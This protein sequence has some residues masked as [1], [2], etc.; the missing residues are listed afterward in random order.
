MT[1]L[2]VVVVASGVFFLLMGA[3][4]GACPSTRWLTHA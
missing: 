3:V 1:V 2:A 4:G